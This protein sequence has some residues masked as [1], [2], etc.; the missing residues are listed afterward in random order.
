MKRTAEVIVEKEDNNKYGK[1]W[2]GAGYKITCEC[3]GEME[4]GAKVWEDVE[5]GEQY[6]LTRMLGVYMFYHI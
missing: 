4:N 5:T 3:V 2:T 1:Q 6:F